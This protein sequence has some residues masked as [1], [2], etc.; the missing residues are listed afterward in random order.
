MIAGYAEAIA[1][2]RGLTVAEAEAEAERD[3]AERLPRGL[4]TPGQL[5]RKAV[6]DGA[7]VGWIWLTLPGPARPELAWVGDIEVDPGFRSRGYA[8]AIIT[9]VEA[10]LA[11]LG[12]PR[13]GLNVFGTNGTAI[14]VYERLGFEVHAQQRSRE[15]TGVAA[16]EGIELTPMTDY[17]SRIEALF[18]D[19]AQDLVQ[20][21]GLWHGEAETR[22]A[23]KLAEL[24]P[25][26]VRTEGMIL[27]TVTAGGVPVGW[28]WA[29]LPAPPRPGL[30]WLH[31]IEIDEA[32]RGR[33]HGRAAIAA[34][35]AELVRRGVRRMGLNVHGANTGARRLYDRLGYRLLAQQMVKDLPAR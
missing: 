20:E 34:V 8:G 7:E 21:Q 35:E 16:A 11:G 22:A 19:Y 30:G 6:R 28:V 9:A 33:G 17:E 12:V 13:L 14:G 15:L 26:G 23:H 18:A 3:V 27:R 5:M 10:E 31:N 25:R 24:L 1:P 4:A 2:A 29:G 32:R